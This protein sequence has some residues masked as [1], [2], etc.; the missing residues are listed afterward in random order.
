MGDMKGAIK[1][2]NEAVLLGDNEALK[3]IKK[4]SDELNKD[5]NKKDFE[6]PWNMD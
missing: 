4:Y 1:D 6:D 3:R 5:K 2:W